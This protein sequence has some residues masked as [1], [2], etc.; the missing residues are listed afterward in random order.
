M[1]GRIGVKHVGNMT[2][3]PRRSVA[4]TPRRFALRHP[5]D[6]NFFLLLLVSIWAGILAGFVPDIFD[7]FTGRHVQYALIVPIHAAAFVGWLVLLTTQ[8]ALIRAGRADIHRRLG[9]VGLALILAMAVL[10]PLTSVVMGHLE[11]GTPN[12]D[13]P[14]IIV[15][16]LDMVSFTAIALAGLAMRRDPA[17]HRR[18]MLLATVFITDA[19]FGRW[20]GQAIAKVTGTGVL[21]F[22]TQNYFGEVLLLAAMVIHDLVTRRTLHPAFVVAALA[23]LTNEVIASIV[24]NLP[25][26]RPIATRLIGH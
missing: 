1:A 19:G 26:W 24:Y 5:W 10:G 17:A 2:E 3:Q 22:F 13:P 7:H 23:G 16:F 8:L 25:A 4:D 9:L 12:N 15:P 11:F 6:R 20:L 18:L 14:F 21:P